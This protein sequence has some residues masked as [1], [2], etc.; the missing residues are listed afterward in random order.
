MTQIDGKKRF[1]LQQL[2]NLEEIFVLFSRCTRL[3]FVHCDEDTYNDQ[4]FIFRKEEDARKALEEYQKDKT[5]VQ[6]LKVEK[7]HFLNFYSSLYFLGVNA[8]IIDKG[9]GQTEI[10][11]EE[12]VTPPDYSKMQEGQIR[13]DNPQFQLTAM[14]L[15]QLLRREPGVQPTREMQEMEEELTVNMRRGNYIVPVQEDKKVP[16]MKLKDEAMFQPV[17]TDMYEF[18]K[19]AGHEKFRGA[20]VPFDKLQE[21]VV[22]QAKGIIINPLGVH[23]VMMKEQLK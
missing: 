9:E 10:L 16:L 1:M 13:V 14:Y 11:L 20:V 8:M 17:F 15:M 22:E 7:D 2:R 19:F 6:I 21:A 3:P 18:N 12:L 23:V 4:I 5:P